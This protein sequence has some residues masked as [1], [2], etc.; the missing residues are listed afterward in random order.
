MT[1]RRC[2]AHGLM[3]LDGQTSLASGLLRAAEALARLES[4]VAAVKGRQGQDPRALSTLR[5]LA[6][7]E[8][9]PLAI[10]GGLAAIYHGYERLTRDIDVVVPTRSLD[11]IARVAP[12]YGIKVSWRDPHG[13]HKLSYEGLNID[14][15]PEGGKPR[16]DSPT[17]IPGPQELGVPEGVDYASLAGWFETKLRSYRVQDR[18]DVVQV[19]KITSPTALSKAR[20]RIGKVHGTYRRRFDELLAE[21]EE[22]KKQE[23]ERGGPG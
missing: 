10:V 4:L 23:R 2:R 6:R 13:W 9:I 17:T 7:K 18:A 22:E 3:K 12:R 5:T 16:K 14:V 20:T 19:M 11:V 8:D 15:V 1:R 21:A